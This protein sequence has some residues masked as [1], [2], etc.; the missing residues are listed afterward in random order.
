MKMTRKLACIVAAMLMLWRPTHARCEQRPPAERRETVLHRKIH[1][2]KQVFLEIPQAPRLCDAIGAE[3]RRVDVGDCELYCEVEGKGVPLVLL[4]GGPGAT[5]HCFHPHFSRAKGF[6]QVIYYD[7]RGCGLSDYKK[8]NGYTV[9]QAA[10]DLENLRRA[11]KLEKWVVLGHSYGGLLGQYYATKYPDSLGG[12]VLV[13]SSPGMHVTL[14][15]TRQEDFKSPE[16]KRRIA[17]VRGIC[18]QRGLPVP[19]HLYNAFLNGDW[20]RQYFHRPSKERIAQI[21]RYEWKHDPHFRGMMGRSIARTD[22][23][24]AFN[25]CPIPTT[26]IEGKWDLTW[27]TDKPEKLRRNH[28][29]AKLYIIQMAG[30]CPFE[31]DPEGFF[32][33]LRQRHAR[34]SGTSP[35]ELAAWKQHLAQWKSRKRESPLALVRASGWGRES[36]RNIAEKY[37]DKWLDELKDPGALLRLGFALYDVERYAQARAAFAKLAG[38]VQNDSNYLAVALIWQGHML[39]LLGKRQQAIVVYQK[40]AALKAH[41][42]MQHSQ[43]GMTYSPSAYAAERTKEPFQRV[44]NRSNG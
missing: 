4:H 7:Q 42:R 39:D 5:H 13:G 16:E 31:D 38:A 17:E 9:D 34:V 41:G 27:N 35:A 32:Q 19:C 12:L 33:I 29:G 6:A 8:S 2:E 23:E 21:A 14:G 20:K 11:L 10:D 3:K 37:S 43:Y 28:P 30:H 22:L 26:I 44:Q 1:I 24:G 40:A 36:S 15:P 18:R 25:G